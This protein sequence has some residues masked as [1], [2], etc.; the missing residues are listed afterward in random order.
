MSQRVA[1]P[2]SDEELILYLEQ[3]GVCANCGN[4][5]SRGSDYILGSGHKR[6]RWGDWVHIASDLERCGS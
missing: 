3:F 4:A 1:E 6:A 2:V 5:I